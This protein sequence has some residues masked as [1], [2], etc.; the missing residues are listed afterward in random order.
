MRCLETRRTA[1]GYR[2]RRYEDGKIRF[3]TIEVPLET[4]NAINEAERAQVK[5]RVFAYRDLGWS[6]NKVSYVMGIPRSTLHRWLHRG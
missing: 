6:L 3:T 1:D 2:R 4:W 5:A